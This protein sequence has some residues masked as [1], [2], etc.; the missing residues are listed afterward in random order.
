[1]PVS[2]A[3]E[4][5]EPLASDCRRPRRDLK[6]ANRLA[7]RARLS[8]CLRYL[9]DRHCTAIVTVFEVTFPMVMTTGTA[10]PV[11]APLPMTAFT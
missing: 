5:S 10:L 7:G 8:S 2:P 3:G 4:S 6:A 9:G 11:D 1:M